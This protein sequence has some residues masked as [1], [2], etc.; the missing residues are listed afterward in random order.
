VNRQATI[1]TITTRA[2]QTRL[3][4]MTPDGRKGVD[5]T[6][7][8]VATTPVATGGAD[9]MTTI[10]PG[11][12]RSRDM[13]RD[14]T[15]T[16]ADTRTSYVIKRIHVTRTNH[17]VVTRTNHA[18]VTRTKHAVVTKTRHVVVLKTKRVVVIKTKHGVVTKTRHGVV[19]KMMEEVGIKT[20]DE[21]LTRMKDELLTRTK[22]VTKT[23]DEVLT[24]MMERAPTKM[25]DE[26]ATMMRGG[27]GKKTRALRNDTKDVTQGDMVTAE[28]WSTE[29]KILSPTTVM[30]GNMRKREHPVLALVLDAPEIGPDLVGA[31]NWCM[32]MTS[33]RNENDCHVGKVEMKRRRKERAKRTK[34]GPKRTIQTR[35]R[36]GKSEKVKR[37]KNG[38]AKKRRKKRGSMRRGRRL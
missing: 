8:T 37:R 11:V 22:H 16:M 36:T 25:R 14:G 19:I 12:R 30:I 23:R 6:T 9:D 33:K 4:R 7:V 24:K 26:A 35:K 21:A 32:K 18:V 1:T 34:N 13:R 10:R 28:K 29:K 3:P 31:R 17:A 15:G 20:K 5:E 2:D 27:T 38:N